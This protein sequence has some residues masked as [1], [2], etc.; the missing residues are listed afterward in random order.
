VNRR[1]LYTQTL[2]RDPRWKGPFL[3]V[4]LMFGIQTGPGGEGR[5]FLIARNADAFGVARRGVHQIVRALMEQGYIIRAGEDEDAVYQLAAIRPALEMDEAMI[6]G[7]RS[8]TW[9]DPGPASRWLAA[10][11]SAWTRFQ[12]DR[13]QVWREQAAADPEYWNVGVDPGSRPALTAEDAA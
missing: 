7:Q 12:I 6:A 11:T 13:E 8:R 1:Q 5:R 4:A 9:T 10:E 3:A 2:M